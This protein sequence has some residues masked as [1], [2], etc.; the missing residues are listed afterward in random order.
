MRTVYL[1]TETTGLSPD[2]GAELVELAL[3][4]DAGAVLINTLLR[5]TKCSAWPDAERIH[6]ISPAMVAAAP[7]LADIEPQ[8]LEALK[9]AE[10]VIYNAPFDLSFLPPSV[11]EAVGEVRCAMQAYAVHYGA[12]SD[13]HQSYTWQPLGRA[14]ARVGH[15]WEGTAHRAL[16]DAGACRSVWHYLLAEAAQKLLEAHQEADEAPDEEPPA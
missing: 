16:A 11:R 9:G 10:V 1:D 8:L 7:T 14:A 4:D 13:Y 6:R 3:I 12:W 15:T 2:D 5:P